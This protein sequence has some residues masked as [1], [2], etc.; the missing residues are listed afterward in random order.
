MHMFPTHPFHEGLLRQD[1]DEHL[2]GGRQ[3]RQGP[4]Q[5][6]PHQGQPQRQW[7]S[8]DGFEFKKFNHLI[9]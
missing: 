4:E 5:G 2:Q 3:S 1:A 9:A 6:Q 8:G 7:G